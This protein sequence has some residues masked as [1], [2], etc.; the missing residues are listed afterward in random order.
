MLPYLLISYFS[1]SILISSL[2]TAIKR[3]EKEKKRNKRGMSQ[4]VINDYAYKLSNM[5]LNFILKNKFSF[6][7]RK[8]D[9]VITQSPYFKC[10]SGALMHR[11]KNTERCSFPEQHTVAKMY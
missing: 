6:A 1:R 4:K 10:H 3:D 8:L 7:R 9:V 2:T 5:K 11:T